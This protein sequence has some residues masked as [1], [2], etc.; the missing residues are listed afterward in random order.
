ML[1]AK[2]DEELAE[3]RS[4][5]DPQRFGE[6]LGDVLWTLADLAQR[7]GIDAETAAREAGLRFRRR[8]G[9]MRTV[10]AGQPEPVDWQVQAAAW[11]RAGRMT[12]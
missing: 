1:W 3:L 11:R 8:F 10:L 9:R 7:Y 2:L 6:E 4:A 12:E 5:A